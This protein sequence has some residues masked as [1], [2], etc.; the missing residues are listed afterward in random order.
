MNVVHIISHFVPVDAARVGR[1][2]VAV[3]GHACDLVIAPDLHSVTPTCAACR[4]WLVLD[5]LAT[6][7]LNARWEATDLA[8]RKRYMPRTGDR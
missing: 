7:Q 4:R 6:A 5:D 3:C 8:R 1:R 2:H